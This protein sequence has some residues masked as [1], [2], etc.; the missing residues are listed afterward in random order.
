MQHIVG[1]YRAA[2]SGSTAGLALGKRCAASCFLSGTR[3]VTRE[4]D[5]VSISVQTA[6]ASIRLLLT[7]DRSIM[8]NIQDMLGSCREFVI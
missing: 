2:E 6:L 5:E 3:C 4:A 7:A 8:H 1:V